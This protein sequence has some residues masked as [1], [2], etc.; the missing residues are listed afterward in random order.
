MCFQCNCQLFGSET[1]HMSIGLLWLEQRCR[2]SQSSYS[3]ELHLYALTTG[4]H[5]QLCIRSYV[6][7]M[8]LNC[9]RIFLW[10]TSRDASFILVFTCIYLSKWVPFVPIDKSW[11][12]RINCF[13]Y[14][15]RILRLK[16]SHEQQQAE[17]EVFWCIHNK[18]LKLEATT[19]QWFNDLVQLLKQLD[20]NSF[21]GFQPKFS[22]LAF[23]IFLLCWCTL[24]II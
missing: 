8:C 23:P 2:K 10:M 7:Y 6:H 17:G 24:I 4:T 19:D 18:A 5:V 13:S 11:T 22:F 3:K 1:L 9:R 20:S 12:F 16:V 21:F 15:N 14:A